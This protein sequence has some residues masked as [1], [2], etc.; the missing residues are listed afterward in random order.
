LDAEHTN[1]GE[2]C[3]RANGR[4]DRGGGVARRRLARVGEEGSEV[5]LPGRSLLAVDGIV[6][7]LSDAAVECSWCSRLACRWTR[8][9]CRLPQAVAH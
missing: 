2:A 8:V 1:F 6:A 9:R 4:V 7:A 5:V 3:E